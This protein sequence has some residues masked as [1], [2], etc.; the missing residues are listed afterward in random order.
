MK[1]V[2]N[3]LKFILP[4]LLVCLLLFIAGCDRGEPSIEKINRAL[5]TANTWK[6]SSVMVDGVDR[7]NLF[8]NFSLKFTDTNFS[9]TNG[10][11]VWPASGT[12]SFVDET[13]MVIK[14][15]DNVTVT[16]ATISESSLVL[17]LQ[18]ETTTFAGGRKSSV[19]GDH[20]FTF[21]K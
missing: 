18:W 17:A 19:A 5:V 14:R 13:A 15:N 6:I 11:P 8:A 10:G 2:K 21:V 3:I 20:V 7:T 12:W 1:T 9:T 16:I 4:T